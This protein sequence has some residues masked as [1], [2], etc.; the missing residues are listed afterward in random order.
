MPIQP[1][2]FCL[3]HSVVG[4]ADSAADTLHS[5]NS[6]IGQI[7]AATAYNSDDTAVT[8]SVYVL[9]PSTAA[10]DAEPVW[11]QDIPPG[12][13]VILAGLLGHNVQ[14]TGTIAAFASTTDVVS[15]SISG[16]SVT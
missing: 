3:N 5:Q 1:A 8:L 12:K 15:V 13:A 16:V 11:V 7:N 9:P 10:E 14:F 6:G 2:S 4:T